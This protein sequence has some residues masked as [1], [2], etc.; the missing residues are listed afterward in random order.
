[1][2]A[3]AGDGNFHTVVMFDP[4]NDE[5]RREASRL[6]HLMV[7]TA[8]SMEGILPLFCKIICLVNS[9]FPFSLCEE[10]KELD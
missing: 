5:H 2:I 8:L 6:N 10:V 4:S 7:D 1:M 9:T 3:H